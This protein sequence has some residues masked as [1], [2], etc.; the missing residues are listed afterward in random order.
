[1][2]I[3]LLTNKITGKQYIGQTIRS[4]KRRISQHLKNKSTYISNSLN[5]Y[6]VDNFKIEIIDTASNLE[7]LNF[8]EQFYIN[9]YKTMYP[10]GYNLR[11]GGGA[12][13][14]SI[15]LKQKISVATKK[16][17]NTDIIKQKLRKNYR[18]HTPWN[19]GTKGAPYRY[20]PV[21]CNETMQCFKCQ[22]DAAVHIGVSVSAM[23]KHLRYPSALKM[24]KNLTF[25][26]I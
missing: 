16:A 15:E 6:G 21:M 13:T 11:S 20:K 5:K 3:Y 10:I 14:I 17:M 25:K 26:Y 4:I 22:R 24:I 8:K 18:Y 7:D 9:V 1:M 2:I 12:H 19:K 23:S